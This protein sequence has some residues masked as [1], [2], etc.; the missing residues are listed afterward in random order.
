V[1]GCRRASLFEIGTRLAV[2]RKMQTE[3]PTLAPRTS[4]LLRMAIATADTEMV[5]IGEISAAL[6][7]RAFGFV[8]FIVALV[9]CVPLPPGVSSLAG[10]PVFLVGL[11]MLLG[12]PRPW[13]PRS[14]RRRSYRRRVLL[15]KLDWLAPYLQIFEKVARPRFPRLTFFLVPRVAGL[16]VILLSLYI[17]I[18]LVFTNIPP[19][20]AAVFIAF[21]MIEE[22]GLLIAVGLVL[23]FVAMGISTL[24][25]GGAMVVLFH[26]AA[27]VLGY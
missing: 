15:E 1:H 7:R 6:R 25:A 20:M 23:A 22:D 8:L 21:A 19:A 10:V 11:Q 12:R 24:L 18:P 14:I 17:M 16:V 27:G 9:N 5:T 4:Q 26:A 13:L 3:I 2:N